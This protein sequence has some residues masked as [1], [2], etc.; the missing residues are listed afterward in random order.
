M[1]P[2]VLHSKINKNDIQ[3]GYTVPSGYINNYDKY[4]VKEIL[5]MAKVVKCRAYED[6]N[7]LINLITVKLCANLERTITNKDVIHALLAAVD[8]NGNQNTDEISE[9]LKPFVR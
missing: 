4:F 6:D 7:R 8:T 3:C 1:Y 5:K 9:R 2:Y